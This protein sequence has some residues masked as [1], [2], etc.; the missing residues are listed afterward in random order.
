MVKIRVV[1][2]NT[3]TYVG[4][5]DI[6][7]EYATIV[8]ESAMRA[9]HP[10]GKIVNSAG[11]TD[12]LYYDPDE[13]HD[14]ISFETGEYHTNVSYELY[15]TD[16]TAYKSSLKRSNI[17][18]QELKDLQLRMSGDPSEE[19]KMDD[20]AYRHMINDDHELP[21]HTYDFDDHGYDVT[22]YVKYSDELN[23]YKEAFIHQLEYIDEGDTDVLNL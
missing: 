9:M 20:D 22:V 15:G 23:E 2:F 6:P 13:R 11:D 4:D 8:A 18:K 21:V 1:T 17:A 3:A 5:F 7:F 12:V 10:D 16:G 14:Y 19:Q